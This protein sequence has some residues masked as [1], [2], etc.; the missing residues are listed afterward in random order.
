VGEGGRREVEVVL[1]LLIYA[2]RWLGYTVSSAVKVH[3]LLHVALSSA[4]P[5]NT[6]DSAFVPLIE[7]SGGVWGRASADADALSESSILMA[8]RWLDF[9]RK[10][11]G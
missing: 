2:Y 5:I 1:A 3:V 7:A 6:P 11:D 10:G 8:L 9:G 4:R